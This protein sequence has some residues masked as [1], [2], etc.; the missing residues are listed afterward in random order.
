MG[1]QGRLQNLPSL[2]AEALAVAHSGHSRCRLWPHRHRSFEFGCS[3]HYQ[4]A[5]S[6]HFLAQIKSFPSSTA[7][8]HL[9]P[10]HPCKSKKQ[11]HNGSSFAQQLSDRVPWLLTSLQPGLEVKPPTSPIKYKGT[12]SFITIYL[13]QFVSPHAPL[14]SN[15]L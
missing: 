15:F 7:P 6:S 12:K 2:C 14:Q 9:Q 3:G 10:E 11:K 13:D 8:W 1:A 4:A 5:S